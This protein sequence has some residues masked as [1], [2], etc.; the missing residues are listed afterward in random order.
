MFPRQCILPLPLRHP[1]GKS[2]TAGRRGTWSEQCFFL[3]PDETI[4]LPEILGNRR[5]RG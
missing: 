2:Q 5:G 1:G 4:R 3:V